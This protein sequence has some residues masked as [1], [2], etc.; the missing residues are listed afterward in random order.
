[1]SR[2]YIGDGKRE[3]RGSDLPPTLQREALNAYV[4]RFTGTHKPQWACKPMPN[5]KPYPLQ[6]RDDADWLANTRF[7]V[8]G[9]GRVTRLA[10]DCQST[11]TWPNNPEL[12]RA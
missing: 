1:M 4:H 10:G 5:G 12:R 3:M 2:R 6:F 7:C 9:R 11:P 8:S